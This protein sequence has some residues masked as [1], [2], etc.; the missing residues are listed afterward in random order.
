MS[1]IRE[2]VDRLLILSVFGSKVFIPGHSIDGGVL[3]QIF[4][5]TLQTESDE[6]TA[7]GAF[8]IEEDD[9]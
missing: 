5:V 2:Q 7:H 9:V 6:A 4:R 1:S 3:E 8:A